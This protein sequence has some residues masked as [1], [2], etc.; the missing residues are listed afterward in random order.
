MAKS[1]KPE[2]NSS[3]PRVAHVNFNVEKERSFL[4]YV[5]YLSN[6]WHIMWR[7]FLVGAFQGLGFILG[8][9]LLLAL[10]G[11][12]TS[13]VLI[14]IPLVSDFGEAIDVWLQSAIDTKQ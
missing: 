9:A 2:V 13:K 7:N 11:F 10:I 12:I 8:S 5:K 3:S 4:K 14:N 1:K 6:P